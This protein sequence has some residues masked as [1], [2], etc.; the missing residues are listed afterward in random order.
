MPGNADPLLPGWRG[1]D[2]RLAPFFGVLA[3]RGGA[4]EWEEGVLAHHPGAFPHI[5]QNGCKT[6]PT[7]PPKCADHGWLC[8]PS[9]HGKLGST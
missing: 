7:S 2:H 1:F 3:R 9:G 8:L 5:L 6:S 4:I